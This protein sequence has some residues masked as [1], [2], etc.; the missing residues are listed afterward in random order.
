MSELIKGN[1]TDYEI[2]MTRLRTLS[3]LG[4]FF[5]ATILL[6]S[7]SSVTALADI[8]DWGLE[9]DPELG[10]GFDVWANVTN[11]GINNDD[12]PGIK[13]VTIRVVG[14]NMSLFGLMTHNGTYYTGS[15]PA[16]PNGGTFNVYLIAYNQT[17]DPRISTNVY[18]TYDPG[19]PDPVD[20]NITM[21]VVVGSSI[22]LMVVVLVIGLVYDRRRTAAGM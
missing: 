18:I 12:D 5:V 3:L 16:F 20:P 4:L 21:P 8:Y 1:A 2:T 6:S 19:A 14:P 17:D 9:G 10:Q 15:V 7:S 11:D 13:N 22:A